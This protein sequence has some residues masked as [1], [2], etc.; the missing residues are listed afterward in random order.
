M[1]CRG[2]PEATGVEACG[3]SDVVAAEVSFAAISEDEG[4]GREA[5]PGR[6]PNI[7]IR[8]TR[9]SLPPL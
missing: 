8:R 2:R 4:D 6:Q 9:Q 7:R 1:A 5:H 3:G